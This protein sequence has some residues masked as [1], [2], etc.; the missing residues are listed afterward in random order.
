MDNAFHH[1]FIEV[2]PKG[3][4]IGTSRFLADHTQKITLEERQKIIINILKKDFLA[5]CI[6]FKLDC[7]EL[8]SVIK[9]LGKLVSEIIQKIIIDLCV[10]LIA[11]FRKPHFVLSVI[12]DGFDNFH[13]VFIGFCHPYARIGIIL[14][15]INLRNS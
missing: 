12:T 6:F 14:C 2:L 11:I 3:G 7:N 5:V 4:H 9:F 13:L 15:N 8:Q 10:L 1:Q